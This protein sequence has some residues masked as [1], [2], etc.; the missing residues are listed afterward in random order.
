MKFIVALMALGLAACEGSPAREMMTTAA[1]KSA[2]DTAYCR[3]I[4]AEPGTDAFV[5]CRLARE[6]WRQNR[7]DTGYHVMAAGAQMM[8]NSPPPPT[9]TT[10][11][12]TVTPWGQVNT[13]CF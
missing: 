12:S 1:Q 2:E 11:N 7:L 8:A 13:T 6:Q 10:C 4:G 9:T 5:S 3:G